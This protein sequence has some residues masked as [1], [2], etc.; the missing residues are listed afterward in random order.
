MLISNNRRQRGSL[1]K[2]NNIVSLYTKAVEQPQST[3]QAPVKH[4]VIK[5]SGFFDTIKEVSKISKAFLTEPQKY[6]GEKHAIQR[7]KDGNYVRA[8]YMGPG[9]NLKQRMRDNDEPVSM[10]DK[11]SQAHDLRY[12][13]AENYD[14]MRTADLKMINKLEQIKKDK[15]DSNFNINQGLYG[16][17]A[18]VALENIGVPKNTFTNIG[19]TQDVNSDDVDKYKSKLKQLEQEGFGKN[20]TNPEY[21]KELVEKYQYKEDEPTKPAM[22]LL[23]KLIKKTKKQRQITAKTP[24]Y[25]KNI[26]RNAKNVDNEIKNAEIP[27]NVLSVINGISFA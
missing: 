6:S 1:T 4:R 2:P 10:S 9:T 23:K 3:T 13:L 12:S 26:V 22:K 25:V 27:E 17:K 19:I 8:N 7:G 15:L 18:K 16:I 14:D 21:R 24:K 11:V 5:G 20:K